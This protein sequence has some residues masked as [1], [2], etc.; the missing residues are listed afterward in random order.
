[1]LEGAR[2]EAL[3]AVDLYNQPRQPR[4]LEG[5]LVHMHIAWLYLLHAEFRRDG[6]D[7][8]YRLSNGWL[9][10]I[11]GEPKTWDLQ[12]CVA[13]RWPTVAAVRKNLEF[14]IALRNKVEH[15]YH[16]AVTLVTSGYAQALLLNFEEELTGAFGPQQSLGE[17]LRFPIFVGSITPLG[18]AQIAQL[19]DQ[20]PKGTR[21]FLA[22]Y[23]AD[24]DP[25]I[26][27]DQRYEFRVTLVP[28]LGPK[29]VADTSLTFVRESDLSSE[30]K[31]S[32][33]TLGR[34]GK[35]IVRQQTRRVSGAGL[36]KPAAAAHLIQ[37]RIPFR[38][39]TNHV[40]YA[41][42]KL[43]CRPPSNSKTPER[44]DEKYCIYDE[45]HRDYLYTPA[46][47]DKIA[48]ETDTAEKFEHFIGVKP[49]S[50]SGSLR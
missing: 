33:K 41:W 13:E 30:E 29:S 18:Q 17:Q 2:E 50:K 10:R 24:L 15:R 12:R 47:L 4:R 31:E 39:E 11:D 32:L 7:Y 20:L 22:R 28:K 6:T 21:D 26:M 14:S 9:D 5:F 45:P 38:F 23:E 16:E 27:R 40:V 42:K 44:T 46:F 25:A 3:L 48:R 19:R 8:R 34:E 37:E 36:V 43:G 49:R 1:M 35:V